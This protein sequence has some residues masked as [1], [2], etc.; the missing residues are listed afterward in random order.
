VLRAGNESVG[1]D[2]KRLWC[3]ATALE[4][5][6]DAGRLEEALDLWHGEFLPGLH[7]DGGEFERWLDGARDRLARR[8]VASCRSLSQQAEEAGDPARAIAWTRR[9]TELAPYDET[10]W[11][12]LI[13][14]LDHHGDRAGALMAYENL[15]AGLREELE[16][17][18]SP[19]TR[20]LAQGIRK[21]GEVFAVPNAALA[22]KPALQ[23]ESA[24]ASDVAGGTPDTVQQ[25]R[26]S[27][28]PASMPALH[29]ASRQRLR[30]AVFALPA[31]ALLI[32]AWMLTRPSGPARTVIEFP[33]VENQTGDTTLEVARRRVA[34]RLAE[35]LLG[36][37]FVD[38]IA[39]GQRERVDVLV[40]AS[41]YR[42]ADQVE[43][44][45]RLLQPGAGGQLVAMPE[46]VWIAPD[47]PD[48]AIDEVIGRVLAAVSAQYDPRFEFAGNR[49]PIKPP[50]WEAYKEY[51][52]GADLFGDKEYLN[53]AT[54][55]G[56]S[57]RLGYAKAAVFAAI[58]LA[59]GGEPAAADSFASRLLANEKSLGDY[60]RNFAGWFLADLRGRRSEAYK[61]AR[62]FERAAAGTSPSAIAVAAVEAMRSNRPREATRKFERVDVDHGWLRRYGQ[63]WEWWAGAHHMRGAYRDELAVARQGR[64]RFPESLEIIRTEIR[65]RV[66]LGQPDQVAQLINE[67]LTMSP[68]GINP[69]EVAWTAAQ[70]L[71]AHGQPSQAAAMRRA[72]LQWLSHR[73]DPAPEETLLQARL[74]LESGDANGAHQLLDTLPPLEGLEWLGLTGLVAAERKDTAAAH[75]VITRLEAVRKPYLSGRHLL[76]ASGILAALGESEL[77]VETLRRALAEGLPFGVELHALPMLRPLSGRRDFNALLR[78][79]G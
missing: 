71:A 74:L 30:Y 53:A 47:T 21:R 75:D 42:R 55:L 4:S 78:A 7:V 59:Y 62:E 72:A 67:S 26:L 14:L 46:A 10:G 56:E 57:Y 3:D 49:A 63:F 11:Q 2:P 39:P 12:R 38:V 33:Q 23:V 61:A 73:E 60:E 9:L 29:R 6:M 44:R 25:S 58:A 17:E 18:P 68:A 34:D 79:R 43:V 24:P 37:E 52:R 48:P 31:V 45:A 66:A 51:V 20:A 64:R 65:A 32:A 19:E 15:T 50:P 1:I 70:E 16:V 40:S 36:L 41:L 69:A 27:G 13:L 8:A 35:A 22:V 54:H 76:L 77:A 28:T 5:A